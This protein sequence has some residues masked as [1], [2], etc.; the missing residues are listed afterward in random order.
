M[1]AAA[2]AANR[3]FALPLKTYLGGGLTTRAVTTVYDARVFSAYGSGTEVIILAGPVLRS[4][5]ALTER[6]SLQ[7]S[8]AQGTFVNFQTLHAPIFCGARVLAVCWCGAT[9]G[10]VLAE[11]MLAVSSSD[12]NVRFFA[13]DLSSP[14]KANRLCGAGAVPFWTES[15]VLRTESPCYAIDF[16]CV[17]SSSSFC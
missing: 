16:M 3:D 7:Q 9:P 2:A 6:P 4:V 11:G 8:H 15:L 17:S 13:P 12:S 10:N 1:A 14:R 5:S